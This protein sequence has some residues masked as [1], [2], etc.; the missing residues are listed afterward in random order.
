VSISRQSVSSRMRQKLLKILTQRLES[1]AEP[2]LG[3]DQYDF[4]R[5]C[6]TRDAIAATRVI[7][8]RSLERNNKVPYILTYKS[9][10]FGQIFALKVGGSTYRRV[11][12]YIFCRSTSILLRTA[13]PHAYGAY[14][15]VRRSQTGRKVHENCHF[16]LQSTACAMS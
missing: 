16:A 6:G 11:I 7:C 5:G 12:K 8:D 14:A 9:K 2:Y 13:F 15:Q 10:N 1:K 4:M 3:R